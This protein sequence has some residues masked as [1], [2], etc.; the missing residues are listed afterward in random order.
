M[1]AEI[2]EGKALLVRTIGRTVLLK[3]A[4]CVADLRGTLQRARDWV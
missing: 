3:E 4:R 2:K 1:H